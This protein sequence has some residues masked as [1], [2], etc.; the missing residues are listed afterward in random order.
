MK[1][2]NF[3]WDFKDMILATL[4]HGSSQAGPHID[5]AHKRLRG[6]RG[7]Y[8]QA[9]ESIDRMEREAGNLTQMLQGGAGREV[10]SHLSNVITGT[11]N[12]GTDL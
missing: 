8:Q 5:A 2:Y 4:Y 9:R 6:E 11:D 1:D 12:D 3:W 10:T 7:C